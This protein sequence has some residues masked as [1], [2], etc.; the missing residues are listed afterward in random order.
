MNFSSKIS[1]QKISYFVER[2]ARLYVFLLLN[3]YGSGKIVGGQFY[4]QGQLPPEVATQTLA[5]VGS[6]DLAWT[7]MGYSYAYILFIGLSQ[8]VGAWLLLW[9]RTKLVGIAILVPIL[10]NIIVFDAI[11]FDTYGALASAVIYLLLLL[12]VLFINRD[13]VVELLRMATQAPSRGKKSLTVK[14]RTVGFVLVIM[15]ALFAVEQFF[16]NLFGH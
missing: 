2:A 14:A 7:F 5:E 13:K 11:F 15:A 3:V 1:R 9:E 4:R 10:I 16:I 8:M 6:F 12:T